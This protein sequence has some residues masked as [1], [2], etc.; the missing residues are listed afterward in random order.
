MTILTFTTEDAAIAAESQI[1]TNLNCSISEANGYMMD[2]WADIIKA[3]NLD[4]WYFTK[5]TSG[6]RGLSVADLMQDVVD[7][8]EQEEVSPEWIESTGA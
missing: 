8:A 4:I 2:K 5:P 7:Y 3:Y 1:C 6:V